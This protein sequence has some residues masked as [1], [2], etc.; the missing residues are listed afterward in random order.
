LKELLAKGAQ[1]IFLIQKQGGRVSCRDETDFFAVDDRPDP[2]LYRKTQNIFRKLNTNILKRCTM[3]IQRY[4]NDEL[5]VE[6]YQKE[7]TA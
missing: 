6:E 5:A 4:E 3:Y 7:R 2:I 1:P